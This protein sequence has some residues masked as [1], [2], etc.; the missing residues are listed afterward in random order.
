MTFNPNTAHKF[1]R[2]T[3]ENQRVT[4]STPWQ[5]SYS[6]SPERFEH[7]RQALAVESFYLGRHYFEVEAKG[8]GAHMGL[9]YKSINR[10]SQESDGCITGN[11]FSWC[12]QWRSNGFSAWHADVEMPL[13]ASKFVRIGVYVDY[14]GGQLAFYGVTE[15]MMLLHQ[16]RA[17]FLEPLHPAV[18]LPKKEGAILLLSPK[19][20]PTIEDSPLMSPP[21]ILSPSTTSP[22]SLSPSLQSPST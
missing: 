16:F 2:L 15:S 11:D 10:K 9:T 1:L 8:D 5:Q 14:D 22:S 17:E 3:M 13:A 21:S 4:N 20:A 6:D 12:L 18:W 7:W 19:E